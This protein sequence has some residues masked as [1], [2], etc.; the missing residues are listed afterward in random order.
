MNNELKL[1]VEYQQ[2]GI[3]YFKEQCDIYNGDEGQEITAAITPMEKV[4]MC[5][6]QSNSCDNNW[7]IEHIQEEHTELL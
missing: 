4:C 2:D 3:K 7:S 1:Y 5:Y 6:V